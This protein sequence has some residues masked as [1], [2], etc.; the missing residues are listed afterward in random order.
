MP[1]P[2]K[3]A[4]VGATGRIGSS[5]VPGLLNSKTPEYE[6]AALI[7]PESFEKASSAALRQRG[8]KT[9][10]ADLQGSQEHLVSALTGQNVVICILPPDSTLD[11]IPLASAALKAGKEDVINHL[12]KIY[13]PY[14]VIDIGFWHEVMIPRIGSEKL[15]HVALYSTSFFV[16]QGLAPCATTHIDDAGRFVARIIGDSR[17]INSLVFAYGEITNQ[18]D[19]AV[20]RHELELWPQV[21]LEYAYNAWARGDNFPEK[22]KFLGYLD[23]K[24]LWPDLKAQTLEATIKEALANPQPNPGFGNDEKCASIAEALRNWE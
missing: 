10:P 22:A 20:E 17:T 18:K 21:I 11:Q 2:I 23:A 19:V 9:V 24:D 12:K 15:N 4:I 5:G 13:L 16:D 1:T 7:R 6:I 3:V 14:T 8:V